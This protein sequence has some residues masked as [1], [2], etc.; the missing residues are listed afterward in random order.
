[1]REVRDNP[2]YN[3]GIREYIRHRIAKLNDNLLVRQ[4]SIDRLKGRLA[5]QITSFKVTIAKVLDKGTPLAEKI[6]TLFRKQGITVASILMAIGIA[7][8]V[9]VEA[10]LPGGGG[11][12]SAGGKPPPKNGK[13]L[14][15]WI[16][17]K[18]KALSWLPGRLGMKAAEALPGIIGVIL[19]WIL[20][21]AADVVGWVSQNLWAL[22]IG[23]GGLLYMYMVTK[24]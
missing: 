7:V 10:L 20:N 18:L 9:L 5:N 16:K 6:R 12:T 19:S 2:E 15:E 1:M 22:V 23:I 4:E 17:N 13:S 11:G 14:K 3:N 24:K 8:G 21:K